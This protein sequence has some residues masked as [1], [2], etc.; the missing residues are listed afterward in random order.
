MMKSFSLNIRPRSA[1]NALAATLLLILIGYASAPDVRVMSDPSVNF[2]L[3]QT[4]AFVSPLG[5]DRSGYQ[6]LVSQELKAA[7]QLQSTVTA[8]ACIRH[9]LCMSTR[10]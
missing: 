1:C 5:T 4:F 3:Y 9:G 10:P 8:A 2:A 6:T 7:T